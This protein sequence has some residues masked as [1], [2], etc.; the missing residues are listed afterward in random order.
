MLAQMGTHAVPAVAADVTV[1]Q[2]NV[3][4]VEALWVA[5][6]EHA[7]LGWAAKLQGLPPPGG[8]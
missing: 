2:G 8:S 3:A 5:D 1:V 6:C 4:A 7:V